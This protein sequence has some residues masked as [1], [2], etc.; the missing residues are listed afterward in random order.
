M[1]GTKRCDVGALLRIF[2]GHK[3]CVYGDWNFIR[4]FFV[5]LNMRLGSQ[6]NR[7]LYTGISVPQPV[8][9]E[10]SFYSVHV[11]HHQCAHVEACAHLADHA[12]V[13]EH[14]SRRDHSPFFPRQSGSAAPRAHRHAPPHGPLSSRA[15][16]AAATSQLVENFSNPLHVPAVGSWSAHQRL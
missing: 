2:W 8:D 7:C 5:F 9:V 10:L 4:T 14:L 11:I 1:G 16:V 15:L 3:I 6:R 12:R 13:R